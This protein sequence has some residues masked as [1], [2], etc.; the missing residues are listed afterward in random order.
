MKDPGPTGWT[1]TS[2]QAAPGVSSA[3]DL[4]PS[5]PV[6]DAELLQRY[7]AGDAASFATLYDRHDRPCFDFIRRLLGRPDTALAE[8]LHQDTWLAVARSARQFD[9]GK[10]RFVTWLFTIARHRVMDHFRRSSDVVPLTASL[11]DDADGEAPA[12]ARQVSADPTHQP[13]QRAEHAAMARDILRE[14][15]SLPLAQREAFVLFSFDALSLEDI[16]EVT[17]VGV[18]TAKSRLRYARD[19][20]RRRLADWRPHDA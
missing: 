19:T 16:A 9:P 11:D 2:R 8:D 4:G 20:L 12:L 10:A 5:P 7:A 3:P 17:G 6:D 14:V 13:E 15:Q 18:E 1:A